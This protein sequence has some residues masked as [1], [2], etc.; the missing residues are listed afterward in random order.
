MSFQ[1]SRQFYEHKYGIHSKHFKPVSLH[2]AYRCYVIL[3]FIAT[4][5]FGID[6]AYHQSTVPVYDV[7]EKCWKQNVS[8]FLIKTLNNISSVS[9]RFVRLCALSAAKRDE[10]IASK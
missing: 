4:V 5:S 9:F 1:F 2:L 10:P 6:E 3:I 7:N 8:K